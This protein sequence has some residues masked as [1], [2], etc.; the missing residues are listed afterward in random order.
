MF[1][2]VLFNLTSDGVF[3]TLIFDGGGLIQSSLF[4][5]VKRIEKV[6]LLDYFFSMVKYSQIS[7]RAAYG[8]DV[9]LSMP[10][11]THDYV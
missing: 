4:S 3:F 2:I 11:A 8:L 10:I 9:P 5:F 6:N 1:S 7:H